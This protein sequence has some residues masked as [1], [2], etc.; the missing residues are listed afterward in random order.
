M[1]KVGSGDIPEFVYLIG[2]RFRMVLGN[3]RF[4]HTIVRE[5]MAHF[6]RIF[7]VLKSL[8]L[9]VFYNVF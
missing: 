4:G 2:F 3:V 1:N 5:F 6:W 9:V 7:K 8:K